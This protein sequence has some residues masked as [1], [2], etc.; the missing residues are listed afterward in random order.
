MGM[1]GIST[2]GDFFVVTLATMVCLAGCGDNIEGRDCGAGTTEQAGE[3]RPNEEVCA[4]GTHFVAESGLCEPSLE[5]A[6]GTV[7]EGTSC[8]PDGNVICQDGT[9]FNASSGQ[10]EA[11]IQGCGAGTVLDGETCVP[12]DD[13]AMAAIV[14]ADEPNDV[15]GLAGSVLLPNLTTPQSMFGCITPT[16]TDDDGSLDI[17]RD[18]YRITATGPTLLNISVDGIDGLSGA[19]VIR[20]A[21]GALA[22]DGWSRTGLNL[23]GDTSQ[24]QVFLPA[25]GDYF[26]DILDG[27][28]LLVPEPVGGPETCYFASIRRNVLPAAEAITDT[29]TGVLGSTTHVLSFS[30]EADGDIIEDLLQLPTPTAAAAPAYV[31]MR[32]GIY[33]GGSQGGSSL[34]GTTG[35][36]RTA[37]NLLIVIEPEF[38]YSLNPVAYAYSLSATSVP[39]MNSGVPTTIGVGS[40]SGFEM[41]WTEVFAGEIL[42]LSAND[43]SVRISALDASL[44]PRTLLCDGCNSSEFFY[45]PE[46]SGLLYIGVH[47]DSASS[48]FDITINTESN[49]AT[50]IALDIP[51]TSLALSPGGDSFA[52]TS[53]DALD[54]TELAATSSTFT[55]SIQARRYALD[56][57][58]FLDLEVPA[59]ETV[60]FGATAL[61]PHLGAQAQESLWHVTDTAFDGISDTES[62]DIRLSSRSFASLS[63]VSGTDDQAMAVAIVAGDAHRYRLQAAPG[64]EVDVTVT[65]ADPLDLSIAQLSDFE[66]PLVVT[67]AGG[68]GESE[69]VR[70][71][72]PVTGYVPLNIESASTAGAYDLV[73]HVVVAP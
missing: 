23:V 30:P 11:D 19:F 63:P 53:E 50:P 33:A 46:H 13:A 60:D 70:V 69:T 61:R 37:S 72:I 73:A 56:S 25:A 43:S 71:L 28:S 5:C 36:L 26:I 21:N 18:S 47:N 62:Y 35:G 52:S 29:T 1:R 48:S 67:D 2:R 54:W 14:E 66:V 51:P 4:A 12:I 22:T 10:C 65:S 32:D 59:L 6:E 41:A 39:E 55:G 8:I 20:A 7:L 38:N 27:R 17:D 44:Q 45:Q 57:E 58:G 31:R 3:C 64:E 24:R 42:R 16:D 15:D 40:G 49:V 68:V 34:S 9:R